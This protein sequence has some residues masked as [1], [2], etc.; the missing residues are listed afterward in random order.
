MFQALGRLLLLMVLGVGVCTV[1]CTSSGRTQVLEDE[2]T[3]VVPPVPPR[4]IEAQPVTP[5]PVEEP[6]VEPAAAASTG[7]AKPT[8]AGT[9]SRAAESKPDPKPEGPPDPAS[10]GSTPNPNPPPVMP[11]RTPTTPSGPEAV[12]QIREIIDR[13]SQVLS[14]KVDYQKLSK[15]RKANYDTAK[16]YLNQAEEWLKKEDLTQARLYA[17]RAEEIAQ[18]LEGR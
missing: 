12:K 18:L 1:G 14:T 5:P 4:S 15:D 8:R 17:K 7:T 9:T 6:V 3:L 13:T 2:P 10:T 16:N 11:L